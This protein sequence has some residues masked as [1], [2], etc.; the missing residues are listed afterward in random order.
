MEVLSPQQIVY[1][2]HQTLEL[3]SAVGNH[4]IPHRRMTDD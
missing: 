1:R 2:T 4:P 3:S